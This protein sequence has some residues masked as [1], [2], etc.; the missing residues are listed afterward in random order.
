M[1][2]AKQYQ[3]A[4]KLRAQQDLAKQMAGYMKGQAGDASTPQVSKVDMSNPQG[5]QIDSP[6]TAAAPAVP[7]PETAAPDAP[8][9]MSASTDAGFGTGFQFLE[10]A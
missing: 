5:T 2:L 3:E 1:S 6:T 9:P 4:Q 7:A 8:A 10:G